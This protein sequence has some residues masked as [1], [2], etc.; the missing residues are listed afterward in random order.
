MLR[1]IEINMYFTLAIKQRDMRHHI[2]MLF[3][4]HGLIFYY[5]ILLSEMFLLNRD[6]KYHEMQ[7][8]HVD[9]N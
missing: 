1:I 8:K 7:M 6:Y 9:I 3:Y 5:A 2:P 4:S